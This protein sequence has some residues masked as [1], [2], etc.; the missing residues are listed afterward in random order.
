MGYGLGV[1]P[2]RSSRGFSFFDLGKLGPLQHETSLAVARRPTPK[3]NRAAKG[4]CGI[5]PTVL[6]HFP[7]RSEGTGGGCRWLTYYWR[8]AYSYLEVLITSRTRMLKQGGVLQLPAR[9]RQVG[10]KTLS[11]ART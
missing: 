6:L 4:F 3:R 7:R 8:L 5:L 2:P 1:A 9:R 10:A 11:Q